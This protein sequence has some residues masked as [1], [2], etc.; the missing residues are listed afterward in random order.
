M[1]DTLLTDD[2]LALSFCDYEDITV[3]KDCIGLSDRAYEELHA[4][5]NERR[6]I[7]VERGNPMFKSVNNCLIET[8]TG[9]VVLGCKNSIIPDDGS[10]KAIGHHAFIGIGDCE[11]LDRDVFSH[12]TLPDSVQT[13]EHHAFADSGLTDINLPYGLKE[14]G[15][16]AFMLT[17]I[18]SN[19]SRFTIP[20]TVDKMGIGVFMGCKELKS[21]RLNSL[22]KRYVTESDCIVDLETKTVIAVHNGSVGEMMPYVADTV[23]VFTFVGQKLGTKY[24]FDDNITDIKVSHLGLPSALEFP[25]TIVAPKGC[26]AHKF[27]IK[28]NIAFEDIANRKKN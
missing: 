15:S 9:R 10:I 27:A 2:G 11:S 14:I 12:I 1:C 7:S 13:I 25:I 4:T 21:V 28:H 5:A 20:Y 8:K 17:R 19:A 24:Y 3:P 22:S 6:S 16:M 26:Y 18:G 23:E